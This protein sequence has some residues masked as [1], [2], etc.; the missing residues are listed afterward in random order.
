MSSP[1]P[2]R[3]LLADDHT[4]VR[5]GIAAV[6]SLDPGLEIVAEA[7]DGAGMLEQYRNTLPDI[8][9]L[10]LRMPEM[11]GL[12]ALKRLRSEF[13][14]A[15]VLV[16]TTSELVEDMR[17]TRDAGASGYLRKNV[18]R[19]ELVHAIQEIHAGRTHISPEIDRRL[20]ENS[21]RRNLTEREL[22]VLDCIRR[23]LSN[24]DI[25]VA[26]GMSEH[27]AKTHVKAILQKLEAADRTE[28]VA[29]AFELG[30]LRLGSNEANSVRN[31]FYGL[32][33]PSDGADVPA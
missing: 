2:I 26:L 16:L 20:A 9:L 14:H 17:R 33:H 4:V 32:A 12:T 3:I 11:D 18:P 6:L 23:G 29:N 28:A 22:E 30:I 5:M 15:R 1:A 10:D 13:P 24:R 7:E 21:R 8:V 25:S 31:V 27:T 19:A